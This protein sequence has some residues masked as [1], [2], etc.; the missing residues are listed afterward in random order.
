MR[1]SSF[2]HSESTSESNYD[3]S[4]SDLMSALC[5]IFLLFIAVSTMNLQ[6]QISDLQKEKAEYTA[7]NSLAEKYSEMQKNLHDD[8][9]NEFKKEFKKWNAYISDDLTIHF[10]DINILFA[11]DSSELKDGF[12]VI[13]NTFFP[14]LINVLAKKEYVDEILEIRI[15]G[16]TAINRF[17]TPEDDYTSGMILSQNRT[18]NV[19]FYCLQHTHPLMKKIGGKDA[20]K[21]IRERI[22]AIGYSNS[23][24]VYKTNGEYDQN[25]S[26]RVEIKIKTKA[27]DVILN[28]Q[29]LSKEYQE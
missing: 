1:Y 18:T 3:L 20:D 7:K 25:T 14:R 19:L 12:K 23:I 16:H 29:Q 10:N 6:K 9:E 28:I 8:I 24:P 15:E 4:I 26:R 5:G 22:A 17:L 2:H 21:W 11:P 27:E 13:L